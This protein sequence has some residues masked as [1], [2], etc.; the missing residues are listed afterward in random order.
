MNIDI[1]EFYQIQKD[2]EKIILVP[3]EDEEVE[4]IIQYFENKFSD[5]TTEGNKW[6]TLA[7]QIRKERRLSPKH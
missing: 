3:L 7:K 1:E 4:Q 6:K 5:K 2:L